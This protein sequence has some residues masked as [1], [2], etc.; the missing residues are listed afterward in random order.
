M[1]GYDKVELL[2]TILGDVLT[3]GMGKSD[4]SFRPATAADLAELIEAT[5]Q[6]KFLFGDI[7][8]LRNFATNRYKWPKAGDQC[9]VTQILE[10][11]LRV[12]Y[13]GSGKSAVRHDIALAFVD[14]DGEIMEFVHDSR[15]FRKVGTIFD[16]KVGI[17]DKSAH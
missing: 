13:D 17:D 11:P 9:V 16:S 1:E 6:P 8:E 5:G 15:C 7:V 2:G 3:R 4:A 14:P 12:P 10:A